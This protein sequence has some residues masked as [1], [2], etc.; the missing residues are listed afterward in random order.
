MGFGALETGFGSLDSGFG[1]LETGF[2]SLKTGFKAGH[3]CPDPRRRSGLGL[4]GY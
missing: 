2:G 3:S 1:A 4:A